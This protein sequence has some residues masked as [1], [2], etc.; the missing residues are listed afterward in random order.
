MRRIDVNG[1]SYALPFERLLPAFTPGRLAE[2]AADVAIHGVLQDVVVATTDSWGRCIVEG[3]HR[4][5][6]AEPLEHVVVPIKNLGRLTD[7][8]A[9]ERCFALNVKRRHMTVEEQQQAREGRIARVVEQRDSGKSLRA[10]ADD[11]GVSLGQVQRDLSA[12]GVSPDTR[13]RKRRPP[14]VRAL[15]NVTSLAGSLKA[16][17]REP[18]RR[19]AL[20]AIAKQHG[21]P[22]DH[23]G[24]WSVFERVR[25][26]LRDLANGGA[27]A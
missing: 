26:V 6:V 25:L 8:Q 1:I 24:G 12:A 5:I 3:M 11:V 7:A 13:K 17:L 2:L 15:A 23:D 4:S 27:S 16:V 20:E 14:A 9:R 19:K 21:V 22:F 18:S 10:I